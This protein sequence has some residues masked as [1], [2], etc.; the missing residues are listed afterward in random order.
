LIIAGFGSE[1][2][3]RKGF[4]LGAGIPYNTIDGDFKGNSFLRGGNEDILIPDIDGALGFDVMIG[5]GINA[6]WSVELNFLGSDHEGTW[7]GLDGDVFFFSFSVNGKY[8]FLPSQ[9]L[10]PYLLFGI[11]GNGLAL[12]DGAQDFVTGE[13]GNAT[14]SGAGLNF[15]AG[16][17]R[18]FT[19]MSLRFGVTYRF[20]DYDEVEGVNE[21]Y[22]IDDSLDGSGVTV[23]L[24]T[25]Y[26]F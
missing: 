18:Y 4:Y 26:H 10:Q 6:K 3:A 11:S 21:I 19:K 8:N 5:Y 2:H 12:K 16:I 23:M 24:S 22:G 20:V 15:G 13:R 7:N 17:E 25:A 14:F 1:A 9:P